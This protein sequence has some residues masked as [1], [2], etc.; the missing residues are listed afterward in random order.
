VLRLVNIT[1]VMVLVYGSLLHTGHLVEKTQ[2][3]TL[4]TL[5]LISPHHKLVISYFNK[6]L[7]SL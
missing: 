3:Q 2:L 5:I 7:E 1:M 4:H 6:Y